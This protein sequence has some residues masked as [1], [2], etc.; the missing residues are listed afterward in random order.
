MAGPALFKVNN[1][2]QIGVVNGRPM[3]ARG[4]IVNLNKLILERGTDLAPYKQGITGA[5]IASELKTTEETLRTVGILDKG[6]NASVL[7]AS[8]KS[9]KELPPE[10]ILTLR[11]TDQGNKFAP[12]GALIGRY[13]NSDLVLGKFDIQHALQRTDES[14]LGKAHLAIAYMKLKMFTEGSF[15]E[16]GAN[17][18]IA[19]ASDFMGD[20]AWHFVTKQQYNKKKFLTIVA[21]YLFPKDTEKQNIFIN[22]GL[23]RRSA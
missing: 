15:D 2:P 3:F 8:L 14:D 16:L 11:A 7:V 9:G 4:F 5:S 19:K 6:I 10:I 18:D 20:I 12:I 1:L 22:K 21:I 17:I 23:E 13:C